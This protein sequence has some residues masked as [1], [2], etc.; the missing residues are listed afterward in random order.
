MFRPVVVAVL[1]VGFA[2]TNAFGPG[3]ARLEAQIP[4]CDEWVWISQAP[5]NPYNQITGAVTVTWGE[6]PQSDYP[7]GCTS[8]GGPY[9]FRFTVNGVDRTSYFTV[10]GSV[11]TATALPFFGGVTNTLVAT[12]DAWDS[13]GNPTTLTDTYSFLD[14]VGPG[15]PV[16]VLRNFNG[17]NQDRSLCLTV[18]AGQAAGLACGDLFVTH[19]MPAYRTMGRD[20][21]LTLFYSSH[22][23]AP[24]PTVA[25]TV[26]E[27]VQAPNSV[28]AELRVNNEPTPRAGATYQA[29]PAGTEQIVLAF[30]ASGF[31]TGLY[32]FTVLVRNQYAGGVYDG[33]VSGTLIVVNRIASEFGAG[34]WPAGVEQLVLGQSGGAILW[35]GGDGSAAVYNSV[36]T[37]VWARAAGGYRDT[38]VYAGGVYTRTLRHGIQVVFDATGHHI[39]T[40]NRA[41]NTSSFTWSGSPLR[42]TSITVPPA[43]SG[44]TYSFVYDGAGNLDYVT[45]PAGRKLDATVSG[46]NLTQLAD[47]DLVATNFEYDGAH[48]LT[49]RIGRRGYGTVYSFANGLRTTRVKVPLNPATGDTATTDLE[50]WDEKGLAVGVV[51]GTLT[52]VDTAS[53]YTKVYGPRPNVADDATFWVDRWG[54]PITMQDP[55][56]NIMRVSRTDPTFPALVTRIRSASGSVVGAGYNARGNLA[57]L[58]DSTFDGSRTGTQVSTVS[59]VY[60]DAGYP[61]SPT[62]VRTPVDTTRF[63]YAPGLGLPDTVTAQGGGRTA[64]AYTASG[65]LRGLVESITSLG[66]R[67]VNPSTWTRSVQ[68]LTTSFAYEQLGNDT[69]TTLPSGS[70]TRLERDGYARVARAFDEASHRTDYSYD[71]MNRIVTQT[72]YDPQ[73]SVWFASRFFYSLTGQIDSVFDPRG[74]KRAWTYDAGDRAVVMT[75][76]NGAI[77][78]RYFNRA[79]LL[80]SV[81]T[82][83]SRVIRLHYDL[84]GRLLVTSYPQVLNSFSLQ[85]HDAT[86]PGDSIVRSYD[87]VGRLLLVFRTADSIANTWNREGTL[88]SQ[89]QVV[90]SGG[91]LKSDF[92]ADYWTDLGGRR[93]KFFNGTDT[94]RY[95]YGADALLSTLAV[96]WTT[97]QASDTFR[98]AW[99]VLGRRDSVHYV[100]ANAHVSYGYDQDGRLRMVCSRHPGNPYASDYLEHSLLFTAMTVDGL[101]QGWSESAGGDQGGTACSSSLS[102]SLDAAIDVA[103]DQRHQMRHYGISDISYDGSGNRVARRWVGTGVLRDSLVYNAGRNRLTY[104]LGDGNGGT[105]LERTYL[106]DADGSLHEEQ[107]PPGV[108]DGTRLYYY[109]GL[110]EM[111][112][113][114]T[115]K[116]TG[117]AFQWLGSPTMCDYD[118]LGRR[119]SGC[120]GG[121]AWLGFDGDNV[122]RNQGAYTLWRYVHG[123]SPD[124]PLVGM[125]QISPGQYQKHYYLTDANGRQLAF[126]DAGGNSDDMTNLTYTQNGGSEAGAITASRTFENGRAESP[127]APLLSYYRNRYYDQQT[128]RWTQEDPIGVAGGMNL[129]SYVGND[130]AG[131]TDPFG[132]SK[133][134]DDLKTSIRSLAASLRGRIQE[135]LARPFEAFGWRRGRGLA[136]F[137]HDRNITQEQRGLRSQIRQYRDPSGPCKDDDDDDFNP[138]PAIGV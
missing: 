22:E 100:A 95:T 9:N 38:L 123:P 85:G 16:I 101:S 128:G 58:A 121:G 5:P 37:N 129:Y 91:Q 103:Y 1:V 36:T 4:V 80:D 126:T 27:Q 71:L 33:T 15:V 64:F 122:I 136:P 114:K 32:P 6:A 20:R 90:R 42:L 81:R 19:S 77:E 10:S 11:A 130:P 83:T 43:I 132:L 67:V 24:R 70:R 75:D 97:G 56:G 34:W 30:D 63:H 111:T 68:N 108:L 74:V 76:E 40:V 84:A 98:F 137:Q 135:F 3:G 109:N 61:D 51:A 133:Q 94:L 102:T 105:G 48:R 12:M 138:D 119:V 57:Y 73:P 47:P 116:W 17:D 45:D 78:T 82:R 21:S 41:G 125:Y 53:S 14:T 66:V 79:G 115:Y 110:G 59:Y 13:N 50:W 65:P 93:T 72:A 96:Q 62:E 49:R 88:R 117:S 118:P 18:G 28:Y 120:G 86:I 23:A 44:T 112:G 113:H 124:D 2:M 106:Y 55:L 107:R 25:V 26:T 52:A 69:S 60:G 131:Y 35:L 89:R 54:A 46:G 87:G 92:T 7:N 39:Q 29:W 31:A 99:D 127:N 134:C 104:R 8:M